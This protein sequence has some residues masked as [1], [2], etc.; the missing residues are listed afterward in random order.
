MPEP[1][2]N[3]ATPGKEGHVNTLAEPPAMATPEAQPLAPQADCM[4]GMQ[5]DLAASCKVP[6][7]STAG[8]RSSGSFNMGTDPGPAGDS[9]VDPRVTH[10][11]AMATESTAAKATSSSTGVGFS[12]WIPARSGAPDQANGH[13]AQSAI[14][15]TSGASELPKT[16]VQPANE[17]AKPND[18]PS[19]GATS[20]PVRQNTG[21]ESAAALTAM[22][23][24]ENNVG[25][26]LPREHHPAGWQETAAKTASGTS[27]PVER[28]PP[29]ASTL[30]RTKEAP[31]MS[32]S[33]AVTLP[34][35]GAPALGISQSGQEAMQVDVD[36]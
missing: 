3:R 9:K 11:T 21:S 28:S 22:V 30:L 25:D 1:V 23:K 34:P 6:S 12:S 2:V 29:T 8:Y 27:E 18:A 17:S 33:E 15:T 7:S 16:P 35:P 24:N 4:G 32:L 14:G 10:A 36:E 20:C 13:D 26:R 5:T 31:S 19:Q